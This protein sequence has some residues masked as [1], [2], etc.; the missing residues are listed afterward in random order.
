[1][2]KQL[3][4]LSGFL[5]C[6]LLMLAQRTITGKVTDDKG[7][8]VANASVL[9]K[10]TT[11]G[12]T[13]KTDGTYSIDVPASAKA[14]IFSSVDMLTIEKPIGSETSI[15]VSMVAE[16]KTMAEVVVTGYGTQRRK[17]VTSSISTVKGATIANKPIQS[18]EQALAGRATGV[19][20]TVPNGVLNTPPVFRIRGT[21]S[22]SLSSYPLIIVDGVPTPTGDFS[23]TAAAGNAL[24]SINPNDIESIDIAK[25]AAATAIYGSRAANGVV[26]ITTKKGKT[27]KARIS[28][29]ASVGWTKA[30]GLPEVLNAQEYTNYKNMAAANNPGVNSTNPAGAGYTHFATA[31]DASGKV[32]DTDWFGEVYRQGFSQDHNLNV[33]GGSENTTYYFSVGYSDQE[34]ILKRNDFKRR[35]ILFNIDSRVNNILTVGGKISYSNELNLA[36]NT[37]GSLNGEAFNTGGFGRIAMVNAPNVSPYNNNGTYNIA[38]P[39]ANAVGSMNNSVVVGFYNPNV[40]LDLNRQ[41]AETNHIQSNAYIQIKPFKW[42]TLKTLYGIDYLFVD[43]ETFLTPLHGDGFTPVGSASSTLGKFKRWTWTNTAQFDYV[44]NSIHTV[45]ALIGNEQD[46]RTSIGFGLNRQTI[47][48]PV[49]T[50]IQAGFSTP[51]T[52]GLAYGENYLLSTF[53]SLSYDYKKKYFISANMR[54]DE[55]SAFASKSQVFYGVSGG[56]EVG[57]EKF[58]ETSGLSNVLNNFRLRASY[59]KVGNT[60]GIGDYSIYSSYGSGLYGGLPTLIYNSAGNPNLQWETSEKFDIG[61]NFGI[62]KDRITFEFTYYKNDITDLILNVPQAPSAG[63]P[64]SIPTNVGTMYNKGFELGI[65]ATPF[66]GKDFN[67]SSTLNITTNKNEVTSL[68][69]GLTEILTSTSGLETVSRSAVGYSLGYLWLVRNGGVDP[70]TG[71]RILLNAAGQ[72]VLYS[73]YQNVGAG[74]YNWINPDGTRYSE[75]GQPVGVGVTQAKDGVMFGNTIPKVY[76]GWDNTFRYKNFDLNVLLTY[77]L[78]FWVYYGSNAGLHD[79]RFW[80]NHRDV[81]TA[82]SKPGDVTTVPKP[83]YGDNVSNGSGLPMSYNAFK[84]DFVKVKN[85]TLSYNLPASLISKVKL[86]SA[87]V[88]ISGQNL[89]IITDYPGPDP[90]VSS[91]GNSNSGQGIDR[92]TIGNARTFVIGLNISFN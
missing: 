72:Q 39:A 86:S 54:N 60:A 50:V 35:N 15:S 17:D 13:T 14:L 80:N 24:A 10:G 48:D 62:L 67:W 88:Y 30:Y 56:W 51:N 58:W 42:L 49:Y 18:F 21:N 4:L 66:R 27:G 31:T 87:R 68:A 71:R 19:Q 45:R 3:L 33:S 38:N 32:I 11:K 90:E 63:V 83:I 43:N 75:P 2:R 91:N 76:G 78:G 89:A 29:N 40:L 36:A 79:Q 92:N 47:S 8:P 59:G 16:E 26:F 28:Y 64:S 6:S 20:I 23:S 7:N 61:L 52:A 25:D 81:L 53:G 34:G 44:F 37:S 5:L 9:V 84:G 77:Q 70:Q 82:W 65:T 55:Y 41:N 73:F 74:I 1:M 12:T 85:V 46:R 69:P 22:I 57:K